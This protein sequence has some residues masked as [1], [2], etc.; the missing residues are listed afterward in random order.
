MVIISAT[1]DRLELRAPYHPDLPSRAAQVGGRWRGSDIGWVFAR[2]REAEVRS[3]CLGIWGHDGTP[4]TAGDLVQI[5]ISVN[6]HLLPRAVFEAMEQPVY[7][8]GHE[9][10]AALKNRRAARPGRGVRFLAGKPTC[11]ACSNTWRTSIPNGAVFVV[12]AAPR[13]TVKRFRQEV[14]SAG[15]IEVLT[16]VGDRSD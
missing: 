5:R 15:S 7:L 16:P 10:A 4:E 8:V 11:I 12:E 1:E 2:D 13:S 6:E 9:I 14:G 3:V